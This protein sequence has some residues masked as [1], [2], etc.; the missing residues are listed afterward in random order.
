MDIRQV[1]LT[2]V[3]QIPHVLSLSANWDLKSPANSS[4]LGA[5]TSYRK[6][7]VKYIKIIVL[8]GLM[9]G[10]RRDVQ[11]VARKRKQLFLADWA[12]KT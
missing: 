2:I 4:V 6:T 5:F 11:F 7:G 12:L 3:V 9:C 1:P 8:K 10:F